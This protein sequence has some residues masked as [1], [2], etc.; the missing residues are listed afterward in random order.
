MAI[1][2][3]W[4]SL[5]RVSR[6]LNLT[7]L[8]LVIF[9][10]I[11]IALTAAQYKLGLRK[12]LLS[13]NSQKQKETALNEK[14]ADTSQKAESS[15]LQLSQTE[16]SLANNQSQLA[17]TTGDLAQAQLGLLEAK[18]KIREFDRRGRKVVTLLLRSE[19]ILTS[20]KTVSE[21]ANVTAMGNYV[22]F[23]GS[24]TVP[25]IRFHA[26]ASNRSQ[27]TET[28]L[29]VVTDLQPDDPTQTSGLDLNAL[30]DRSI[31]ASNAI[32]NIREWKKSGLIA[33]HWRWVLLLNGAAFILID[34]DIPTNIAEQS[35]DVMAVNLA[36]PNENQKPSAK[37]QALFE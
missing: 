33:T 28:Q 27:L 6:A 16:K 10:V 2:D 25:G 5:D 29:K 36:V 30:D 37:Y 26:N 32:Q 19:I 17:L 3:F 11:A 31:I 1:D 35:G 18:A 34:S 22:A 13:G 24:N 12:D 9:G 8:A 20:G 23:W 14:L 21:N 15:L 4:N 7:Q